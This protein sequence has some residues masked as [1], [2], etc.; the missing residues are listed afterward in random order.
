MALS[1]A[2]L[3]RLEELRRRGCEVGEPIE[4]AE[5][6][7]C[8]IRLPGGGEAA[9]RGGAA[10]EAALAAAGE[11]ERLIDVVQEASEESFPASDPPGY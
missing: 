1:Q 6:W 10:D 4:A 8:A 3:A 9:G 2:T 11:A 5:G 7:S